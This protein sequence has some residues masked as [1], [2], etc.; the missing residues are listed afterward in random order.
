MGRAGFL[1]LLLVAGC[2][3]RKQMNLLEK[4]KLQFRAE[5]ESL[6]AEDL[7]DRY[8]QQKKKAD[9]LSRDLLALE[10]DRDR[11]YGQYDVLRGEVVRLEREVKVSGERSGAMAKALAEA[12]AEEAKLQAELDAERKA[13]AELETQLEAARAKHAELATTE[14]PD[15]E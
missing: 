1:V 13:I 3:H 7:E 8:Q 10:R 2:A 4:E 12:K 15:S 9:A 11:L 6:R 14:K 5:N